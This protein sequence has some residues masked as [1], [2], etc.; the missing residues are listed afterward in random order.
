MRWLTKKQVPFIIL[1][2]AI[3]C[4]GAGLITTMDVNTPTP[5]WVVFL[6]INGMGIGMAQQLPYTAL[7]A[8]LDPADVATGNAIAVFS[9]QLGGAL[10]IAIAQNLFLD[11]LNK[12][13]PLYIPE[14]TPQMVMAI[15]ATGLTMLASTPEMLLALRKA[16][17]QA[18]RTTLILALAGACA[19]FPCAWGMEWLNIRKVAEARRAHKTDLK[20]TRTVI[21][22]NEIA[23]EP[24]N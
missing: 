24:K 5:H 3:D 18:I 9:Y 1:G 6:V 21:G 19:A 23:L 15:G 17:A 10:G 20:E 13:V 22:M 11:K 16:Y 14:V 4:I 2:I 12:M 7:Q 8:V